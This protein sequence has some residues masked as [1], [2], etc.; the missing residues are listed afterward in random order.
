MS[1]NSKTDINFIE[2]QIKALSPDD[3]AALLSR[4]ALST[5]IVFCGS[6]VVSFGSAVQINNSQ[7]LNA[8]IDK[9]PP[10]ALGEFLKA[11][12]NYIVNHKA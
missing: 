7:D 3:R 1:A 12:G 4:L 11:I 2:E 10:E 9:I 5:T 6:S 8:F